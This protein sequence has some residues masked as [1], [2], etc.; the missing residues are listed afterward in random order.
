MKQLQTKTWI[1]LLSAVCLA[2]IGLMLLQK[3]SARPAKTAQVY[4]DGELFRTIDLSVDGVYRIESDRG[5][6]ELTVRD[7][8]IAVT[9]ASCPGGDCLKFGWQN[10]G[11]PITCLPN[12]MTIRFTAEAALDGIVR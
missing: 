1:L 8:K 7:G 12:R 10:S 11:A 2:L 4:L 5:W 9:A 6:N 3:R